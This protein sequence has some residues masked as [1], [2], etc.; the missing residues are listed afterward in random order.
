MALRFPGGLYT[1]HAAPR[2][3]YVS[4]RGVLFRPGSEVRLP[5]HTGRAPGELKSGP[6]A[7]TKE[8]SGMEINDRGLGVLI[9]RLMLG[10][11]SII[12]REEHAPQDAPDSSK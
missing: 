9:Y 12:L 7:K 2:G 6:R 8:E 1:L 3:F 5:A 4:R 11:L 10:L